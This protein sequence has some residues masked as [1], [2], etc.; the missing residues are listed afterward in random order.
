[1]AKKYAEFLH[2][3]ITDVGEYPSMLTA[4]GLEA[5]QKTGLALENPNTG[6]LFPFKGAHKITA[7]AIEGFLDDITSGRLQPGNR[8]GGGGQQQVHDEL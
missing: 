1:M 6:D 4:V 3:T 5:G 7:A 2:F 8:G